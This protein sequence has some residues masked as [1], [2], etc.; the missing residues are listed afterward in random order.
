MIDVILDPNDTEDKYLRQFAED[1]ENG[2]YNG[3]T[4]HYCNL[5]Y[6][7]DEKGFSFRFI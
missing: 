4:I 3:C 2:Y 6:L 1:V 7:E 5:Y